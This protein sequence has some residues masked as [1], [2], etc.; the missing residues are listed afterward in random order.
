MTFSL[1][2]GLDSVVSL[3][4]TTPLIT[5]VMGI[6]SPY[7]FGKKCFDMLKRVRLGNLARILSS[8]RRFDRVYL[9]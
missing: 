5:P 7:I 3:G 9:G 4:L 1:A 2:R 6:S 8:S